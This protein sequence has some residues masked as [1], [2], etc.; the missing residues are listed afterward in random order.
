MGVGMAVAASMTAVTGCA[1]LRGP[2]LGVEQLQDELMAVRERNRVLK[3]EI[4]I[5]GTDP[6]P[7]GLLIE[8]NQVLSTVGCKVT[9]RGHATIVTL[10]SDQVFADPFSLRLRDDADR[11]LDLL[12]TALLLHPELDIAIV[13]HVAGRPIPRAF[14]KKFATHRQQSLAMADTLASH[15]EAHYELA[16]RRFV[17]SGRGAQSPVERTDADRTDPNYRIEVMLY[18]TGEPPPAPR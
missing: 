4:A 3:E 11:R 8:L 10:T 18:R 15:L 13:G 14:R 12:A 5:C 7:P 6:A 2:D 17:V 1:R 9:Q 16:A